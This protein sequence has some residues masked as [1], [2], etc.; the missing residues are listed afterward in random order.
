M[1][2]QGQPGQATRP[3]NEELDPFL[4]LFLAHFSRPQMMPFRV[5]CFSQDSAS[6]ARGAVK[7]S[8][9]PVQRHKAEEPAF[10]APVLNVFCVE[11][12]KDAG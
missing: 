10:P 11:L 6:S 4:E 5:V 8:S 1:R 9:E 7:T 2:C 3:P 12:E